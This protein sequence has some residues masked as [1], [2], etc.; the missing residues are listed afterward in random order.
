[1]ARSTATPLALPGRRLAREVGESN[2]NGDIIM[3]N[4]SEEGV[5]VTRL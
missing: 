3:V 5:R 1:M 2:E 4:L